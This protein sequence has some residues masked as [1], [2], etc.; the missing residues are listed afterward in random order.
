[1]KASAR[2]QSVTDPLISG[3]ARRIRNKRGGLEVATSGTVRSFFYSLGLDGAGNKFS[4][5]MTIA[6]CC[7]EGMRI[8]INGDKKQVNSAI[9]LV[10]YTVFGNNCADNYPEFDT[11]AEWMFWRVPLNHPK[12]HLH[13]IDGW[14]L[15]LYQFAVSD[16]PLSLR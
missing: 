16:A 14:N 3:F 5:E 7:K 10:E 1:M 4:P 11:F 9:S 12:E 13:K 8:G 2:L 6:M 15:E